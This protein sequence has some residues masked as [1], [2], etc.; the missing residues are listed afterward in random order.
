MQAE[1]MLQHTWV[2]PKLG[3]LK[4]TKKAGGSLVRALML[5]TDHAGAEE[6]FG[7][8]L[9][10]QDKHWEKDALHQSALPFV[11]APCQWEE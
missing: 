4:E 3:S 7:G 10:H 8:I 1:H 2:M 6:S 11:E 5:G 9:G